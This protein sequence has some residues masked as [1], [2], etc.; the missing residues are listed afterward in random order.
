MTT[1]V[2]E[3]VDE[4]LGAAAGAGFD[5]DVDQPALVPEGTKVRFVGVNF[6]DT[7]NRWKLGDEVTFLVKGRIVG[8]TEEIMADGHHRNTLKVDVRSVMPADE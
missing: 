4:D 1:D 8:D 2:Q 5:D 3:P 7:E 6:E